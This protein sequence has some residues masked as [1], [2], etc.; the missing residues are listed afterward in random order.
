MPAALETDKRTGDDTIGGAG[1]GGIGM[2]GRLSQDSGADHF[3]GSGKNE[4]LLLCG[5]LRPLR[6][7]H[8]E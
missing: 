5:Q 1:K 2:S 8:P 6:D 4:L 3:A 7:E